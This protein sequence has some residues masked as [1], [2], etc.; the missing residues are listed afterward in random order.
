MPSQEADD[1]W[2]EFILYTKN[3]Q[4]FCRHALG[5]FL[6]HAPAVVI[7]NNR[8]SNSGLRRVWIQTCREELIKPDKPSRLPL[9]F[10][11]DSKFNIDDGFLYSADCSVLR[12]QARANGD[13]QVSQQQRQRQFQQPLRQQRFGLWW[14]QRLWRWLWRR[15][16]L[17]QVWAPQSASKPC[18][19]QPAASSPQI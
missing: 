8:Q 18:F 12:K 13:T 16:R 1:L 17:K 14:R 9:L 6:H 10:A 2:H 3:Y 4:S 5:G 7:G 11:L 15:W 19:L